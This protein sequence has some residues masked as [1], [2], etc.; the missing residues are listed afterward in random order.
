MDGWL[1]THI[2]GRADP[3][4]AHGTIALAGTPSPNLLALTFVAQT[5]HTLGMGGED[6]A[7]D[8]IPFLGH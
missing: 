6:D 1:A 4:P 5:M 8:F 2:G 7:K 3:A